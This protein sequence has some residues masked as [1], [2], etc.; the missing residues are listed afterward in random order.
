VHHWKADS[1]G[2]H[3]VNTN[4]FMPDTT[5]IMQVAATLS[6]INIGKFALYQYRDQRSLIS[7]LILSGK[8][9]LISHQI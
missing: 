7:I 3:F 8:M 2:R 5:A 9:P 1:A 6:S 4:G